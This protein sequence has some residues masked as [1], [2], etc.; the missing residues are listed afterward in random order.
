MERHC[1][2]C[3]EE[4]NA[5]GFDLLF[6]AS[7]RF[8][9]TTPIGR[10]STI[11]SV[12]YLQEPGRRL[13]ESW[14]QLPWLAPS[15]TPKDWIDTG[16]WRK[17]LISQ[18]TFPGIR[19]QGREERR[20]AQAFDDILVNS[21]FSR[22]S[23]LRAYGLDSKVCYLG[24]DADKFVDHHR[25]REPIA[26]SI[27]AFVPEKGVEF[28]IRAVAR[29]TA[30]V[31]PKLCW[32]A[33]IVYPGYD[34]EMRRLAA[35]HHVDLELKYRL[36]D[37]EMIDILN[38]ARMML[39]APRLE[40]FGFAPLEANA[41]GLP[42]IAVAEGGVRETVDDGV[43]GILVEHDAENMA[44]AIQRLAL[45]DTLAASLGQNG[46]HLVQTNWSLP[47]SIERLESRLKATLGRAMGQKP[48]P[49]K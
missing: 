31:R 28:I 40:P 43:N 18:L 32:I 2:R 42:V 17:M 14:P 12:L 22:E 23:V 48:M 49:L 7:C 27:G 46:R 5:S 24:V 11:P 15:W 19:I 36:P 13:Y 21:Y 34:V 20:N 16:F 38:R 35:D 44:S 39:Y 29:V 9:G 3:A 37:S 26:V 8:F 47:S 6:A 45:D 33:N 30:A 1:G 41:C 4:I 25:Q 10:F